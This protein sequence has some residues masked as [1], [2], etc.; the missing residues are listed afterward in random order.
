MNKKFLMPLLALIFL[1]AVSA[2]LYGKDAA[3]GNSTTSQKAR[4][5]GEDLLLPY[6]GKILLLIMGMPGCAGTERA[7]AALSLYAAKK[8]DDV[9]ILRVDVPPPDG[10]LPS[11]VQWSAP[12]RREVDSG[13]QLAG[14]LGFF[15]YPTFFVLDKDGEVRYSG[16]YQPGDVE[17]MVA[18]I[19]SE[20]KGAEKH[21]FNPPMPQKGN[22]VESFQGTTTGNRTISLKELCRGKGAFLFFGSTSC[23]FSMK[24]T[25]D[26]PG[27]EKEYAAKGVTFTIINRGPADDEVRHFYGGSAPGIP[28]LADTKGAIGEKKFGIRTAPFF[29][30]LDGKGRVVQREPFTADAA[31]TALNMLL[32]IKGTDGGAKKPGAG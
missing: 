14:K 31:R 30:L 1:M 12:F 7:T 16:D 22:V 6:R 4:E 32:N 17:H 11:P 18:V 27:L 25:G 8:P 29:Y 21:F 2:L 24:A 15:Y 10:G 5:A 26:L 19:R 28:V 3:V 20:K 23:P 13:R 9:A